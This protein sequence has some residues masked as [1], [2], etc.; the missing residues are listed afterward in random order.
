MNKTL[1]YTAYSIVA[2]FALIFSSISIGGLILPEEQVITCS[3]EIEAPSEIVYKNISDYSQ[4]S[5]WDPWSK[6]DP[7]QKRAYSGTASTVGHHYTWEGNDQVGK[8]SMTITSLEENKKMSMN[9]DFIEPFENKAT[10]DYTIE[11]NNGKSKIAWIMKTKNPFFLRMISKLMERT[12]KKDFDK[13]LSNLKELCEKQA[14]EFPVTKIEGVSYNVY[15]TNLTNK[16]YVILKKMHQPLNT[17]SDFFVTEMPKLGAYIQTN[18]L[19]M[20]GFPSA[21]YYSYNDEIGETDL[22]IAIPIKNKVEV[23]KPYEYFQ[24]QATKSLCI[25]YYGDY[26]KMQQAYYTI[27]AFAK[28]HNYTING[29]AI[30]EYVGD[31][32]TVNGDMSKCLTKI[33][34]PIK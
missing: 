7:N 2:V 10:V 21:F 34:V 12:I 13:G 33:Y 14:T 24:L 17:I 28:E 19:E 26:D 8:G 30:E 5:K 11:E 32:T 6:L 31:P 1:K 9:L 16:N 27:Y 23:T 3:T 4:W 20:D 18:K 15:E 29:A 22:A 25:D